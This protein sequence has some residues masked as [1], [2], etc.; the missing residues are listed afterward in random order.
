MLTLPWLVNLI[1]YLESFVFYKLKKHSQVLTQNLLVICIHPES[2]SRKFLC[3]FS[4]QYH[5]DELLN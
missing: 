3:K 4:F 1:F 5:E 2:R